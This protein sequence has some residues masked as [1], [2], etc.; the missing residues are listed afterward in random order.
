MWRGTCIIYYLLIVLNCI[1]HNIHCIHFFKIKF[2]RFDTLGGHASG[3][4]NRTWNVDVCVCVCVRRP[5]GQH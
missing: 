3:G 2:H 4:S 1:Y 5:Y